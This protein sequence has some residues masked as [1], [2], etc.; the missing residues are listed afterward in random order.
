MEY[1]SPQVM[2]HMACSLLRSIKCQLWN[3]LK[4]QRSVFLIRPEL[5]GSSLFFFFFKCTPK[6]VLCCMIE[7]V[8]GKS[9]PLSFRYGCFDFPFPH[10]KSRKMLRIQQLTVSS[11][12]EKLILCEAT[13]VLLSHLIYRHNTKV[14]F[15][16]FCGPLPVRPTGHG[17]QLRKGYCSGLQQSCFHPLQYYRRSYL[18]PNNQLIHCPWRRG[19][20][21]TGNFIPAACLSLPFPL[22]PPPPLP[23][24]ASTVSRDKQPLFI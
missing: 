23:L 7:I 17:L 20:L 5:W 12:W 16:V 6:Y 14:E 4:D 15:G 8:G 9:Y 21:C 13:I 19:H 18:I 24:C 11:P 10:K 3:H 22:V 2:L 1:R